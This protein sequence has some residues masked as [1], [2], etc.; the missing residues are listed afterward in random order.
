MALA[1]RVI[2]RLKSS[3]DDVE[4]LLALADYQDRNLAKPKIFVIELSEQPGQVVDGTGLW[5]QNVTVTIGV[6]LVVPARNKAKPDIS[7]ERQL[8][9]QALFGWSASSD[10][11]PMAMAGGQLQPSRPG[12]AAWLD[13]FTAEYTEDAHHA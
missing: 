10:F 12:I 11:E 2:D 13:K 1:Q 4:G 3:F 9:R 5:R 8:I 7:E 6:L